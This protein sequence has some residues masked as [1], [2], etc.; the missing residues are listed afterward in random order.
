MKKA[1]LLIISAAFAFL[2]FAQN[3]IEV[4][5]PKNVCK[6]TIEF[7][8]VETLDEVSFTLSLDNPGVG[9]NAMSAYFTVDDNQVRPWI[10]DEDIDGYYAETNLYSKKNNPSGRITDQSATL[11]M[12]AATNEQYPSN[13]YLGLGGSSDFRGEEGWLVSIYFDA[14]QLSNGI[15]TLHLIDPMCVNVVKEGVNFGSTTYLCANQ[16]IKFEINGGN[17]TVISALPCIDAKANDK[18]CAYDLSG[19]KVAAP[20]ASGIYLENG[21]K[22]IY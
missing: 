18:S 6:I 15:H 16:D 11:S 3:T 21:K 4:G 12:T 1:L 5:D 17:L 10:Y 7:D 2:S 20:T 9:I 19:R 13:L 14:T 22:V 8:E